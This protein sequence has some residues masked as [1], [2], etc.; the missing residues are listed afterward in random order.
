MEKL[1]IVNTEFTEEELQGLF[2]RVTMNILLVSGCII[3]SSDQRVVQLLR[4]K[5][6]C[7]KSEVPAVSR[8]NFLF[9]LCW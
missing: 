8:V 9:A 1:V 3:H 7:V 6:A 5:L 4:M 2:F